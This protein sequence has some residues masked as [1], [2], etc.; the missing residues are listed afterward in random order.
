MAR[1]AVGDTVR[2]NDHGLRQVFGRCLGLAHMKTLEMKITSVDRESMTEPEKT[3]VVCVDNP[4][5]DAYMI[6]DQCFDVVKK[7]A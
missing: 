3:Y 5:I 7:G 1:V 6:D 2:L 4:E